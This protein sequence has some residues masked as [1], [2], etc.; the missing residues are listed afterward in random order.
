LLACP[1]LY[2][3]DSR[4]QVPRGKGAVRPSIVI[5][6]TEISDG[7][8]DRGAQAGLRLKPETGG[9]MFQLSVVT[10]AVNDQD[11]ARQL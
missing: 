7:A 10:I 11:R 3:F 4:R 9:E 5:A 2:I 1:G 6:I 8:L